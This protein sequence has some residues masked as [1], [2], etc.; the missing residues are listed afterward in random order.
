MVGIDNIPRSC[1]ILW[2]GGLP[3]IIAMEP[4]AA[5]P[6]LPSHGITAAPYRST[7]RLALYVLPGLGRCTTAHSA[8]DGISEPGL[9]PIAG[10]SQLDSF[11]PSARAIA[12]CQFYTS[13]PNRIY[14]LDTAHSLVRTY[15]IRR[16]SSSARCAL[17]GLPTRMIGLCSCGHPRMVRASRP[18]YTSFRLRRLRSTW[19]LMSAK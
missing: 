3:A 15:H 6:E 8:R 10:C 19:V 18:T 7:C 13:W 12:Q 17:E 16:S 9:A 5:T 2:T 14:W 4:G 11:Y 1:P